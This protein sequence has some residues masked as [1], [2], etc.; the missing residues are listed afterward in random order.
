MAKATENFLSTRLPIL[1]LVA[2]S[3][4]SGDRVLA[5]DCLSKSFY[6]SSAEHLLNALLENS[7]TLLPAEKLAARYCWV[8]ECL[9]VYVASRADG[10]CLALLVEN[11][12]G[13]QM[14]RIQET[15][16][17]FFELQEL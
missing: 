13:V 1:G 2:Y 16:D 12:P 14:G 3:I 7:R 11:N 8:F 6:P 5:A 4:Q 9:R 15:L 17:A 10:T